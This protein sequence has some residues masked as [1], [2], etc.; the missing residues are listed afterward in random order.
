MNGLLVAG[1]LVNLSELR[2]VLQ[3]AREALVNQILA[4]L[5]ADQVAHGR[6]VEH[7]VQVNDMH[8]VKQPGPEQGGVASEAQ[9]LHLLAVRVF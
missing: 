9:N 1:L 5:R 6:F 2:G 7:F 4:E 8:A 3:E